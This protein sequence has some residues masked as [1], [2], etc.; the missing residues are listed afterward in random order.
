MARRFEHAKG[1]SSKFWEIE[2]EGS[3]VC[4]HCGETGT[5]GQEKAKEF[6]DAAAAEAAAR[7]S[8]MRS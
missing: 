5:K 6:A 1:N 7:S 8:S 4:V 3:T 2:V